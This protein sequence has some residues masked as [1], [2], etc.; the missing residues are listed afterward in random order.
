MTTLWLVNGHSTGVDPADRGLAFGDGL[1]ETMAAHDGD[2][3]WL[4]L[5]MD[6][7]AEGCSRLEIPM[8]PRTL[9]EQEIRA[10]CPPQ[11]SAVI[12]LIVTRGSGERGYR[13]PERATPTR[14]LAIA[15]WPELPAEHYRRGIEVCVLKMRLGENPLLAGLKHLSRLEHVVAQLELRGRA[16]AQGLLLDTSDKIVGGTSSNLFVVR[17]DELATPLLGRCGV[18]GV[19]RRAVL[20]SARALGIAASERE[21]TLDD[22]LAADELFVTN[23]LFG[24]WPIAAI[25]AR[26]FTAGP[27][28]R[29][30]MASLGYGRDA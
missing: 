19:M 3:R 9:L 30:L 4:A 1:F 7:L 2:V 12:K 26:R 24:I 22:V 10:H 28:T 25:D 18:R 13:P 17:G 21:L 16:V 23:A 8:P 15:P 20:E 5:H 29:R 27:L 6:R 14:V 11:R